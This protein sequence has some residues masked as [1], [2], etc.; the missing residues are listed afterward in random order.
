MHSFEAKAS[1]FKSWWKAFAKRRVL[2]LMKNRVILVAYLAMFFGLVNSYDLYSENVY[3]VALAGAL[4]LIG[5][6]I[7]WLFSIRG[8]SKS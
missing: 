7:A 4:I 3:L 5:G 8:S 2:V 1:D 6:L